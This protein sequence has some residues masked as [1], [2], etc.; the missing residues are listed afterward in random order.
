MTWDVGQLVLEGGMVPD[1]INVF[2]LCFTNFFHACNYGSITCF[3]AYAF[4]VT[5]FGHVNI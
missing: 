1:Y 3:Y 4:S 5:I 2:R